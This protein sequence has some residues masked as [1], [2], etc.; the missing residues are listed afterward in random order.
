MPEYKIVFFVNKKGAV[1]PVGD[2]IARR[3]EKRGE[4]AAYGSR[5]EAESKAYAIPQ[6][7][8][9]QPAQRSPATSAPR[10]DK[11]RDD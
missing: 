3:W 2:H 6:P 4:G 7:S 9:P 10:V 11:D 1:I 5:A 8:K